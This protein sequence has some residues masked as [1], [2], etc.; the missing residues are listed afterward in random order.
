VVW[1]GSIPG[2]DPAALVVVARPDGV[3]LAAMVGQRRGS[4]V[5]YGSRALP[6]HGSVTRPWVLEPSV[7]GGS[8]L[9]VCPGRPATITYR[10][11]HAPARSIPVPPSGVV[12]VEEAGAGQHR[13][14]GATVVERDRHGDP[15][16]TT[17][18]VPTQRF[19]LLATDL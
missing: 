10:P 1:S 17:T 2:G 6:V 8:T 5:L 15:V 3:R 11:R 13:A 9:L 12:Q 18:V 19:G 14:R 4:P 7:T 16:R